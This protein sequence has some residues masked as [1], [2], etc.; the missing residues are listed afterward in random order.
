MEKVIHKGNADK[1]QVFEKKRL[2]I[3]WNKSLLVWFFNQKITERGIE[4][5]E[6]CLQL[7][8]F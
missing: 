2:M 6:Y 8:F 1:I 3:F 4:V 5:I 7:L